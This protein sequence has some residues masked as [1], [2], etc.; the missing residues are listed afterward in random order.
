MSRVHSFTDD[1]LADHDAVSLAAAIAE[2]L[3]VA[4]VVD[5]AIARA[6][7]LD[8]SL[9]AVAHPA[10]EQARAEA[11][12]PKPGFFA[13]VPTFLKDNVV[14][15]GMP[16]SH[17]ADA[18]EP[19]RA[20]ADGDFA[21]MFRATGLL[22]LGLSRMS[23][24]GFSGASD[25]PRLGA[26]P[27]PWNTGHYAGASS[28]GAGAMV[29]AGVVPLAHG[30]DGG[31]SIR[32]PAAVNGLVGLKPTRNRLAQDKMFRDMPVRIVSDGVLTRSVRDTA[33]F[34]RE[35]EKVWR[36]PRLAPIGDITR[37]GRSRLKIAV[38]TQSVGRDS[39][40]E[41]RELTLG[42]AAR[43]EE[44]GHQVEEIAPPVPSFF[45]DHFL[46]YWSMLSLF[47]VSTGRREHG[48]S[49]APENLDSLTLG[50]AKHC[51]RN[52][53][54]LPVATATMAAS[55]HAAAKHHATYDV[56]LT[57]TLAMETPPV[58]FLRGDLPYETIMDRL[59][60]W[61]AFTP[62]Q[63][64]SGEPAISLPL[65]T[66]A[67]GLPH[68]MMFGAAA[69]REARLLEL[70]YELEEAFEWPRLGTPETTA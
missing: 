65:A 22:P 18:F 23:E 64:A 13:G 67:K 68:G 24:Y 46:L 2:G 1:A 17:G 52:L 55:K 40:P 28:A 35:A 66:T 50:L 41:V 60:D 59:L 21:R 30:N 37:P 48:A 27:T 61:V 14:V 49:W 29:A 3:P 39:T 34:F 63:N 38:V 5:A 56:T 11:L 53:H 43:L 19:K 57:P 7:A 36:N 51:R 10:Y 12:A 54:K 62:L 25:H 31:G 6:E 58:G 16:S 4:D 15:A 9:N 69:G 8:P 45:P 26:V 20:S 47:L 44:L 70:A 42:V 33:A 32:I